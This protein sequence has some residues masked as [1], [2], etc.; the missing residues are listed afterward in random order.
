MIT[1]YDSIVKPTYVI[2]S[3]KKDSILP[4]PDLMFPIYPPDKG[5]PI[6]AYNGYTGCL[7][8]WLVGKKFMKIKKTDYGNYGVPLFGRELLENDKELDKML[9]IKFGAYYEG[10]Y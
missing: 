3:N 7:V 8:G 4:P 5:L 2:K 10:L 1:R 6:Y 9:K